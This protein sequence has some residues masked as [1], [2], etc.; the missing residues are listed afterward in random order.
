MFVYVLLFMCLC[1]CFFVL[2]PILLS[3]SDILAILLGLTLFLFLIT[4]V[5]YQL[6]RKFNE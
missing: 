5:A 2:L 4:S 3:S 1:G 6:W